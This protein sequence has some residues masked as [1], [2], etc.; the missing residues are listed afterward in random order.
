MQNKLLLI[1]SIVMMMSCS[2][3]P[4]KEESETPPTLP[5]VTEKTLDDYDKEMPIFK[6]LVIKGFEVVGKTTD[7]PLYNPIPLL[8]GKQ[9]KLSSW[10]DEEKRYYLFMY[11]MIRVMYNSEYFK[12]QLKES[13]QYIDYSSNW[14]QF[15]NS[16]IHTIPTEKVIE[17]LTDRKAEVTI[18][19]TVGY[20]FNSGYI[21]PQLDPAYDI[22]LSKNSDL[23]IIEDKAKTYSTDGGHWQAT[24]GP[25][26]YFPQY[27]YARLQILNPKNVM[28][29]VIITSDH[30]TGITEGEYAYP[31]KYFYPLNIVLGN[32]AISPS[33]LFY[34]MTHELLHSMGFSHDGDPSKAQ[35]KIVYQITDLI[36]KT[37]QHYKA[38]P[39]Y[40]AAKETSGEE[41]DNSNVWKWTEKNMDR[42]GNKEVDHRKTPTEEESKQHKDIVSLTKLLW[43]KYGLE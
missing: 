37:A 43:Q 41:W 11:S 18:I 1:C 17:D 29:P 34:V 10:S 19:K 14:G 22:E 16:K 32:V 20:N 42:N 36:S 7:D 21:K 24:L 38:L 39:P 33:S 27:L 35:A 8:N 40:P 30:F 23:Y 4:I 28:D 25:S 15:Y 13:N 3:D 6:G 2:S 26:K 5:V 12:Q 31:Y 9:V